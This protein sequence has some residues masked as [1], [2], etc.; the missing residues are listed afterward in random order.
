[1]E[2]LVVFCTVPDEETGLKLA[3]DLVKNRLAACVNII[4]P[5]KSVYEW[6]DKLEIDT[7]FLLI[8]KTAKERLET[9]AERL[10]TL[11]PYE[12]PEIIALPIIAG[13]V[14]YLNWIK[15]QTQR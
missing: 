5:H 14:K 2:T 15:K 13:T 12:V 6:K 7:E 3:E 11:H 8:I 1:M 9:L 10:N 4:G